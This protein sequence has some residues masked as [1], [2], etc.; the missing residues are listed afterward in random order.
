[1]NEISVSRF[2]LQIGLLR[3]KCSSDGIRQIDHI[4]INSQPLTMIV[5][6]SPEKVYYCHNDHLGTLQI[7]ADLTG[8][9][10]LEA[11]HPPFGETTIN[12]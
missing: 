2:F 3:E 11:T 10:V 8:T 9:V 1:M 6:N 4:H 7:M 5:A 12:V